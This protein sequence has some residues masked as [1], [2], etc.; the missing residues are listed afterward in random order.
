MIIFT[1][2]RTSWA[3]DQLV[4]RPLPKHRTTQT[5][6]KRI[7]TPIIHALCGIRTDDPGFR[8][9]EDSTCLR[10]LGFKI[11]ILE[12]YFY[13]YESYG[14]IHVPCL[15]VVCLRSRLTVAFDVATACNVSYVKKSVYIYIYIYTYKAIPVRVRG[16]P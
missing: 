14:K 9:N 2:G 15:P 10:P 12:N 4:V 1:V 8:P 3:G 6:N 5:Q 11:I 16:G 7:H 13:F